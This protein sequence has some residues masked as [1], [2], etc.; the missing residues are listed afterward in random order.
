[1]R[2]QFFQV[3]SLAAFLAHNP[4]GVNGVNISSKNA[5]DAYIEY[6]PVSPMAIE[7]PL[8]FV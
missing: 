5:G 8:S 2:T 4:R 6:S 1:M 3:L 7:P